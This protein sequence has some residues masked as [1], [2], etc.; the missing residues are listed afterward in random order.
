MERSGRWRSSWERTPC[1]PRSI[2]MSRTTAVRNWLVRFFGSYIPGVQWAAAMRSFVRQSP[3]T[4]AGRRLNSYELSP[5]TG[6]F[7]GLPS[8][9]RTATLGSRHGVRACWIRYSGRNWFNPRMSRISSIEM[10]KAAKGFLLIT[11]GVAFAYMSNSANNASGMIAG[12]ICIGYGA[13]LVVFG[14]LS[15]GEEGPSTPAGAPLIATDG[16]LHLDEPPTTPAPIAP[17]PEPPPTPEAAAVQETL[18]EAMKEA[19]II[20]EEPYACLEMLCRKVADGPEV[21]AIVAAIRAGA[22]E[23]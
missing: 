16:M 6:Q 13:V 7:P 3:L 22:V 2:L 20:A 9:W 8:F 11:I 15:A 4:R 12:I 21:R 1:G 19:P 5:I 14:L 10:S 23:A 18:I 17:R